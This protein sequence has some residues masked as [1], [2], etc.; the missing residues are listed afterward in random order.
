LHVFLQAIMASNLANSEVMGVGQVLNRNGDSINNIMKV[1]ELA[2]SKDDPPIIFG[3]ENVG[4]FVDSLN[5]EA[6]AN[7]TSPLQLPTLPVT[8]SQFKSALLDCI[9]DTSCKST[10]PVGTSVIPCTQCQLGRFAGRAS[11]LRFDPWFQAIAA[12]PGTTPIAKIYVHTR[13]CSNTVEELL[14]PCLPPGAPLWHD[15]MASNGVSPTPP[16]AAST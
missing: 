4:A 14:D 12:R 2:K 10:T 11:S 9:R 13:P 15:V 1:M 16:K 3:W 6:P 7:L 8:S 5:Q